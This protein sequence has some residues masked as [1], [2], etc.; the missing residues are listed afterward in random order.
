V[1]AIDEQ[2]PG[3]DM[4]AGMIAIPP[5]ERVPLHWHHVGEMQLVL[6]GRGLL[7][8]AGGGEAPVGPHDMVFAPAGE[9]G[10]HGFCNTGE[11][12]L[13][14]VFLY[15]SPGGV[16]VPSIPVSATPSSREPTEATRP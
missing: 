6:S 14:M 3:A 9:P 8:D 13:I 12:P 10:A 15:S 5:G 2:T 7:V 1:I 16:W 4:Y 11:L